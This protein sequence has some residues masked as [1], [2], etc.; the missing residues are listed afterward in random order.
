M[1]SGKGGPPESGAKAGVPSTCSL[2]GPAAEDPSCSNSAKGRFLKLFCEGESCMEG[3]MGSPWSNLVRAKSSSH[4]SPLSV[5]L[6]SPSLTD[7][8]CCCRSSILFSRSSTLLSVFFCLFRLGA[9]MTQLRP[10]F[11]HLLQRPPSGSGSHFTFKFLHASQARDRLKSV[12]SVG[13]VG[14]GSCICGFLGS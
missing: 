12:A 13:E 4:P 7:L 10:A 2:D 6:P 8:I 14:K 1:D 9:E 5:S 11:A 3:R